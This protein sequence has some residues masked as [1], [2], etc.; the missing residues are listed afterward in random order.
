[1]RPALKESCRAL[2]GL[3][4]AVALSGQA[5]VYKWVDSE[6]KTHFTDAK[7]G[8]TAAAQKFDLIK[9]TPA[10][11]QQVQSST[12]PQQTVAPPQVDLYVTSWCPYC[13]KAIAFLESN[14]IAFNVYDI[15]QDIVAAERKKSLAP[16]FSGVPLA[17]INGVQLK[18]FDTENYRQ[19]LASHPR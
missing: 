5:E 6:G 17:V 1:M 10:P 4:L 14:N 12:Q 19:A 16:G 18:G 7:P 11:P 13:K 3:A 8:D 9:E 2:F 15:E